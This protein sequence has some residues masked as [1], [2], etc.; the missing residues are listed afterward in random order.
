MFEISNKLFLAPLAGYSDLDFRRIARKFGADFT[1]SEMIS[2]KGVRYRQKK[3]I[4]MAEGDNQDRPYIIQLF[5]NDPADFADAAAHLQEKI[6]QVDGFDV[7]CGCPVRKVLKQ[8]AGVALMQNPQRI[9]EIVKALKASTSLPISIKI[10]LG[11][12]KNSI[13]FL[14]VGKIA[15]DQG[16]DYII[17]HARDKDQLFSGEIDYQAVA[18]L[19]K[20]LSIPVVGNGNVK[21]YPSYRRLCETGCDAVMIGRHAIGNPWIFEVLRRGEK[22]E[23]WE[24]DLE[25]KLGW[26]KEH[27]NA[28]ITRY[29]D[30]EGLRKFRILGVHYIRHI[31]KQKRKQLLQELFTL[32]SGNEVESYFEK[33]RMCSKEIATGEG[34]KR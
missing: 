29:G 19:K 30:A 22:G 18:T 12:D 26:F 16:A 17:L 8:G 20:N 11:W 34:E 13:N 24:P 3:T 7:N 10:R 5:G 25:E 2:V 21:D 6:P 23:T 15:Q 14:E 33:I 27:L 28:F 31:V 9:G 1:V 4:A 32:Q